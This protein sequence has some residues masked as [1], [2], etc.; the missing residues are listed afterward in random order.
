MKVLGIDVGG[1]GIK[2]ALVDLESGELTTERIRF[3]TP[4]SFKIEKVTKTIARLVREFDHGGPIGIGF[5]AAVAEG[6]VMGVAQR[7]DEVLASDQFALLQMLH[8]EAG[9]LDLLQ[10]N[11]GQRSGQED[12]METTTSIPLTD[13]ILHLKNIEIFND[14]SINELAAVAAVTEEAV[15][16]EGEQV[17]KEGDR[18]DT[19]YLVLD[20]NVAVIKER[21]LEKEIELD[22]IGSGDYF[23]EMEQN[24]Q[25]L[26]QNGMWM[27]IPSGTS[28]SGSLSS[29][30][31]IS[32]V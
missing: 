28:R 23:G 25:R 31:G 32:G 5:P 10:A 21:N 7:S 18:G 13:K 30:L 3:K 2:G 15:F 12:E 29:A 8:R 6:I 14:L 26:R 16:D 17:F 27:Y 19:L 24:L 9:F 4:S 22:S 11:P 20:G 1:S